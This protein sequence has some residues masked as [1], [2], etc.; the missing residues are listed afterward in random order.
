MRTNWYDPGGC[1]S[2]D[3]GCEAGCCGGGGCC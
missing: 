3:E 2:D 1:G